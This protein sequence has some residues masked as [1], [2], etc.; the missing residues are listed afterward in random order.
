V[1]IRR[2][3]LAMNPN[4]SGSRDVVELWGREF[5]VVKNGLSEAQV[6]SF[7]N[8][9]AKQHDVLLQRQEHLAALTT[10]AERTVAEADKLAEEMK[11]EAKRQAQEGAAKIISEAET[12][13]KSEVSRMLAEA[14]SLAERAAKEKEAQAL[15]AADKLASELKKAAEAEARRLIA[16]AESKGRHVIEQKE[17]E[18]MSAASSEAEAILA[19]ARQEAATILDKEKRR[20]QPEISQFVLRLR[21]QLLSELDQLRSQVGELEPQFETSERERPA[22]IP[23]PTRQNPERRDEF[24]D[25]MDGPEATES[26]EPEWEVE[27]VP[28]IDIMKIMS[29]VGNVD[30]LAGVARTE[31]IPR[32]DRT[33]IMVYTSGPVAI[34]DSLK[35]LPE[36]AH[37]EETANSQEENAKPR[38]I[39]VGLSSVKNIAE[40]VPA[41][42]DNPPDND[43]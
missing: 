9:L 30:G 7:V 16:E 22:E 28:P 40:T 21:S 37:A 18:A 36:V 14:Q 23:V 12:S 27:I 4:P 2:G 26:G 19:R 31:I 33:S 11:G 24:L 3:R 41:T 39:T 38:R 13:A 15:A 5:N 20:V 17:A 1:E 35:T 10:L 29:I 42:E 34:L 32:N 43:I 25:L 8:D 6:V